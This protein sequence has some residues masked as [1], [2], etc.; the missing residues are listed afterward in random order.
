MNAIVCDTLASIFKRAKRMR[1]RSC[2]VLSIL[3]GCGHGL[4][5][6]ELLYGVFNNTQN[7]SSFD[8]ANPGTLLDQQHLTGVPVNNQIQAI[9]FR[10]GTGDLYGVSRSGIYTIDPGTGSTTRVADSPNAGEAGR[11]FLGASFDPGTA[12]LRVIWES[13]APGASLYRNA[14]IN[15]DTGMLTE[16]GSL[17][18]GVLDIA[19]G[20]VQGSTVSNLYGI[21]VSGAL[22]II[23]PSTGATTKVGDIPALVGGG[24]GSSG[25]TSFTFSSLT[26]TAYMDSI[27]FVDNAYNQV[28]YT[29]DLQ[30]GASSAAGIVDHFSPGVL[31]IAAADSP[32]VPEPSTL[33][34]FGVA[35]FGL[36]VWARVR[37]QE[38]RPPVAES[39]EHSV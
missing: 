29:I 28:L 32:A 34:L 22:L 2:L 7:V 31:Y 8:T 17:P 24:A 19:W 20:H 4:L 6:G 11:G 35:L 13:F 18:V 33:S 38:I 36:G 1:F 9:A 10:S 27:T 37:K 12:N 15:V 39:D 16:E 25:A 14:E 26:G 30:S 23:D 3:V 21:G 5:R